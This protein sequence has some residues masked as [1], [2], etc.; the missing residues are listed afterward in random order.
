MFAAKVYQDDPCVQF[1]PKI[2]DE[3]IYDAVDP[4]L[5]AKMHKAIA[6]IQFK[7]EEA[8]IQRHPEYEMENRM[9]LTAVDYQKGTVMI[10]GKEYPMLDMNFPTIDPRN[11]LELTRGEKELLRTLCASF[12]HSEVLQRQVKFI[13]SHG[14]IY[15]CYNSNLLYHGCI[16]MKKD[17]TFDVI[18]INGK[19]YQ[20]R[21][22]MDFLNRQVHNAYFLPDGS[23][24]KEEA[25]DLMWYLWCGAKSPVFGKAKMTTFEHYFVEDAATHKEMMNPYYKL[26]EKVE[27]CDQILKEF[28]L[29]TEGSHIING[30]V[31]VKLKDGEKPVKAGGKLFVI[32]G[33]LSKS[34]QST[35]GIAGYTL[36]SN[37]HHLALAEHMPFDPKKD[38]T[39]K[40]SVV[41]KLKTRVMV[42]DTDK[43]QELKEQIS[44]LKELVA[45]YREGAIKERAE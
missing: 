12:R 22:L 31:P 25:L 14:G 40:V 2:L 41:E 36:I 29:K 23:D 19:G 30:H 28:G 20:G 9:L 26:C 10:D 45:A 38:S 24:G 3:N 33:G 42:A 35:T 18:M 4:G 6:V 11:P 37:S 8:I 27:V 39:P 1:M 16:P 17:G 32:D 7:V 5:A 34:Y 15:K 43:G 13:Y 21:S 44:D